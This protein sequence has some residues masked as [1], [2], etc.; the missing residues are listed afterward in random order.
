[1]WV[2]V[3]LGLIS[4]FVV[5]T[6]QVNQ[7]TKS[8]LVI[9]AKQ[10][11]I[12]PN[13]DEDMAPKFE[14][15]FGQ[16]I[17]SDHPTVIQVEPGR[18]LLGGRDSDLAAVSIKNANN[19][20]LVGAGTETELIVTNP[21]IGAFLVSESEKV[22][23][24]NL[25]IDYQP[26]PFTQGKVFVVS[27]AEGWFDVVIHEGYPLL[28]DGWFYDVPRP[29]GQWGM[30]IDPRTRRL[31][32]GAADFI[33]LDRWQ[34]LSGRSWR[35]YV[36]ATQKER[37][38]HMRF[39]DLYVQVARQGRGAGIFFFKSRECGLR[40]VAIYA[41]PSAA[42][43]ALACD[44]IMVSESTIRYRPTTQRLISTNADGVHVQQNLR[45]P[46]IENCQFEGMADDG[47]NIYYFPNT[48]TAV[49]S[50]SVL[51]ADKK[52]YIE[53]GDDL[54]LFDPHEGREL[55]RVRVAEVREAT[56]TEYRI[57]FDQ[58]V[59]GIKAG[60]KGF[61]LYNRTRCGSD[62]VIQGNTFKNHRRH[63]IVIKAHNGILQDNTVSQVGGFGIVVANDPDW[64]EGA[65]PSNVI[66]RN[67]R[68]SGVGHSRWYGTD[69]RGAAI[70]VLA[71]A[72]GNRPAAQRLVRQIV[73]ENNSI[74]DPPGAA[75]FVGSAENV[76][77]VGLE[78]FYSADEIPP[79]RAAAVIIENAAKVY[80]GNI[81]IVSKH[82][83]I[84]AGVLLMPSVATG[85][86]GIYVEDIYF[87]GVATIE[88]VK[89][90]RK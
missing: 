27:E 20:R 71:K 33:F 26:L 17:A 37:L 43:G 52:G 41:S 10:Y 73:L 81:R 50:E 9:T 59:D 39:G 76:R 53:R 68:I 55:G 36:D 47:I 42:V 75:L 54:C 45:G 3:I 44:R 40:K 86:D 38:K 21:R 29:F 5:E 69:S 19:L 87:T 64:P 30:I 49:I 66:I 65:I 90:L 67:N 89:D 4:S 88:T 12:V 85:M 80:L 34:Q 15:L 57:R 83:F 46:I 78:A 72:V 23:L 31:K 48:V 63:G 16:V 79:R 56:E 77:V 70:Q 61:H 51:R 18:Y 6:E 58:P 7:N 35:V 24:E 82:P 2:C 62:F 25:T 60:M 22:W 28:T 74:Q 1:M 14:R 32:R 13:T 8:L 84:E 11:D